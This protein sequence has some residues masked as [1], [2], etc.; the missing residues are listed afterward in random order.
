MFLCVALNTAK[1]ISTTIMNIDTGIQSGEKIHHHDHLI[2][3]ATFK[4]TNSKKIKTG[5]N[6]PFLTLLTIILYF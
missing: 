1:I 3:F 6:S 5:N 2:T 4:S